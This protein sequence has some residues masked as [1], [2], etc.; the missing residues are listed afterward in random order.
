MCIS[1][2]TDVGFAIQ[3]SS[4]FLAEF[5]TSSRPPSSPVRKV[6]SSWTFTVLSHSRLL[7][8][9]ES[10]APLITLKEL[11]NWVHALDLFLKGDSFSRSNNWNLLI[12]QKLSETLHNISLLKVKQN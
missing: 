12:L 5:T 2:V 10:R 6:L 8:Y 9:S 11:S 1:S 7:T 3:K 4:V